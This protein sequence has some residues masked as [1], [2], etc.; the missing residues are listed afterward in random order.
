MTDILK[1]DVEG[2]QQL[3][4]HIAAGFLP[5]DVQEENKH[6]LLQEEA[7]ERMEEHQWW[8]STQGN[9][10]HPSSCVHSTWV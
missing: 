10:S 4:A 2:L 7:G 9:T 6:V 8:A 1:E 5:Q 3:N